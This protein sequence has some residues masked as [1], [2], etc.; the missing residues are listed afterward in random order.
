MKLSEK[1][2]SALGFATVSACALALAALGA[3]ADAGKAAKATLTAAG[4]TP[5]GTVTFLELEEGTKVIMNIQGLSP[6]AVHAIHIHEN[7][8]CEGPG[9]ASAGGHFNPANKEHGGPASEHRHVGDFGN[10]VANATGVAKAEFL[11]EGMKLE[12]EGGVIGRAL[13]LHSKA[14]DLV[15]QPSG[16]SGERIACGIIESAP[17]APREMD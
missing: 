8:K 11:L 7:G 2:S 14:D 9:F 16:D 6:G 3:M 1:T 5:T 13:I 17:S 12:G 4:A 10:L 15:S